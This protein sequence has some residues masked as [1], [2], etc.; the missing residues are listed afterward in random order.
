MKDIALS[1]PSL[2]ASPRVTLRTDSSQSPNLSA[3]RDSYLPMPGPERP[4]RNIR[5][6]SLGRS[7][8]AFSLTHN[9]LAYLYLYE[10]FGRRRQLEHGTAP[11]KCGHFSGLRSPERPLSRL[12]PPSNS[13]NGA[14]CRSLSLAPKT[15]RPNADS[16]MLP[17]SLDGD[18]VNPFLERAA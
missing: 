13:P 10:L 8:S 14:S 9:V 7:V 6:L 15:R 4:E 11:E 16:S 17:G 3:Q 2:T 18:S 5:T 12:Y 1:A